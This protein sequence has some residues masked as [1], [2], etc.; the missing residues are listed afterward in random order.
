[1][2]DPTSF[3]RVVVFA[4]IFAG[5]EYRY[6]NRRER[7]L[8]GPGSV[9]SEK[10]VFSVVTPYHLFLLLPLFVIVSYSPSVSAWA[11]NTFLLAVAEDM[12]YFVWRKKGVSKADWTTK[13]LGSVG[14]GPVTI[15]AWWPVDL[16]LAVL[17]FWV[18]Y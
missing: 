9:F 12:S 4:V 6:V 2:F 17:F 5:I 11:G 1:L 13:L 10:P 16:L 8:D 15:P 7:D 18:P 14:T 3:F